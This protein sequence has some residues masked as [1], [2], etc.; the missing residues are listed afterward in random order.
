MFREDKRRQ[1]E[2]RRKERSDILRA[3]REDHDISNDDNS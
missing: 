3:F 2:L 1:Q